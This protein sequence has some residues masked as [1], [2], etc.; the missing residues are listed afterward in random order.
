MLAVLGFP[1]PL[2]YPLYTPHASHEPE[3]V[4]HL[5]SP[6][7]RLQSQLT[8]PH[9]LMLGPHNDRNALQENYTQTKKEKGLGKKEEIFT[10]GEDHGS[11]SGCC[12]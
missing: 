7:D 2:L 12:L 5:F 8:Q 6:L 3:C 4:V 10:G 11:V 1:H 9:T